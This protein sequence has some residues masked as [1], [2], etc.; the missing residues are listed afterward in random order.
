MNE[1]HFAINTFIAL[2]LIASGVA[3]AA[4]WVRV[5]YTLMLVIVGIIIS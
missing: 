4:K 1:T 2:L 3:T 5:P